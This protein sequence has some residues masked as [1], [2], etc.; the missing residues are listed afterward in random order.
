M[1]PDDRVTRESHGSNPK[2]K[3][4]NVANYEVEVKSSAQDCSGS[5]PRSQKQLQLYRSSELDPK[6]QKLVK[7]LDSLLFLQTF[8]ILDNG[9]SFHKARVGMH[10]VRLNS[11]NI[12]LSTEFQDLGYRHELLQSQIKIQAMILHNPQFVGFGL[13]AL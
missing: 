4:I 6:A 11:L 7:A 12:Y 8:W 9:T 3:G 5:K 13:W 1:K 2:K 10:T